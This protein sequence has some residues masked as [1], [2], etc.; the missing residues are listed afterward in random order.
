MGLESSQP[1][2]WGVMISMLFAATT[3]LRSI[4][5]SELV[6]ARKLLATAWAVLFG[7][8]SYSTVMSQGLS[9]IHVGVAVTLCAFLSGVGFLGIVREEKKMQN[10]GADGS[11]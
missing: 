5:A 7:F 2:F 11:T 8:G 1:A 4:V 6:V 10:F 9:G 3:V